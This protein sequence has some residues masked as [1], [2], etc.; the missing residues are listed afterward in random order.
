MNNLKIISYQASRSLV[1]RERAE[2]SHP[3]IY[4][5]LLLLLCIPLSGSRGE[6]NNQNLLVSWS[7]G[8]LST[9]SHIIIAHC[10]S[11]TINSTTTRSNIRSI[12]RHQTT[13]PNLPHQQHPPHSTTKKMTKAS[14]TSSPWCTYNGLKRCYNCGGSSFYPHGVRD[15]K[16]RIF[17]NSDCA[18]SSRLRENSRPRNYHKKKQSNEYTRSSG[19]CFGYNYMYDGEG[20]RRVV[21]IGRKRRKGLGVGEGN[22]GG[23]GKKK[24]IKMG[25]GWW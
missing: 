8:P 4:Y 15:S 7:P 21:D 10:F 9:S 6:K 19:A 23:S 5:Y 2:R 1:Q 24:S 3:F 18:W 25:F 16:H 13:I 22:G 20:N 17:C 11:P 14:D 12:P